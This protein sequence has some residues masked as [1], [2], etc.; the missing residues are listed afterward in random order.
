MKSTFHLPKYIFLTC[1]VP[2]I[3]SCNQPG[4]KQLQLCNTLDMERTD[5]LIVFTRSKAEALAGT[6]PPDGY[7]L[8]SNKQQPVVVQYDDLDADGKWDELAFLQSFKSKE[9][10]TLDMSVADAPAPVKAVVR[11]HVRHRKKNADNSF[12]P[13]ITK[14]TMPFGNP[15]TD[16]SKIPLPPYLTEGPAWENDKVGFRL[17]FDTRNGKDVFGKRIPAMVMDSIGA[18]YNNSYHELSDWGMDVLHVGKSLGAGSVAIA[19]KN[20]AGK[21]TFVRLGGTDV[22]QQTYEVITDGPVR[23]IFRIHY[24]W[25]INGNPVSIIDETSVWGGQY[26]YESKLTIAGAPA[27]AKLVTG[28]ADFYDNSPGQVDTSGIKIFYSF[29]AQGEAKDN[30]GLAIGV[31][32]DNFSAHTRTTDTL[33]DIRNSYLVSQNIETGAPVLYRFYSGWS[34]SDAMFDSENGFHNYLQ[35]QAIKWRK[36]IEICI[37]KK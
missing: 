22:K 28:F 35:Q 37:E 26:F 36:K 10:V 1:I 8:L 13:V 3:Y 15:P 4:V 29:G 21:D 30:L 20:K 31:R 6:I 14:D 11:A 16:F 19:T 24:A 34:K 2:V 25:Q 5:E 27:G 17:Y 23:A 32:S 7:V 18:N 12:G 9:T 33:T